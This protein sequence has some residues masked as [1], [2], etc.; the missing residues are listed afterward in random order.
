M[1]VIAG[2]PGFETIEADTRFAGDLDRLQNNEAFLEQ[3]RQAFLRR[4]QNE[5][6]KILAEAEVPHGPIMTVAEALESE[7]A[8][9]RG[10]VTTIDAPEFGN[11]YKTLASPFHTADVST[12]TKGPRKVSP[13]AA[14]THGVLNA[15]LGYSDAKIAELVSLGA[16]IPPSN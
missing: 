2:V 11:T 14:D 1:R 8:S 7:Q 9:A 16:I 10:L 15:F 6:L 3:A 5:W 4:T 13:F 12:S